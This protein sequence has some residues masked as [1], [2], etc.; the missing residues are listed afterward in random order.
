MTIPVSHD[1]RRAVGRRR[2]RTH[3]LQPKP[4]PHFAATPSRWWRCTS[5]PGRCTGPGRWWSGTRRRRFL[6]PEAPAK[7]AQGGP[8]LRT[9]EHRP[10]SSTASEWPARR[11][12][13]WQ[14]KARHDWRCSARVGACYAM[15]EW[16]PRPGQLQTPLCCGSTS[17][18]CERWQSSR[19]P[20]FE[21][22][23]YPA[24]S[25]RALFV[26]HLWTSTEDD[27]DD[28]DWSAEGER[29]PVRA[30]GWGQPSAARAGSAADAALP[31]AASTLSWCSSRRPGQ[32]LV[33]LAGRRA[34][35][36]V[37]HALHR[38]GCRTLGVAQLRTSA[39]RATTWTGRQRVRGSAQRCSLGRRRV[40]VVVCASALATPRLQQRPLRRD[41]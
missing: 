3:Q 15:H 11:Q 38:P 25:R 20:D 12:Q 4:T 7:P 10:D 35:A 41:P 23:H 14:G 1:V 19:E 40:V 33:P 31:T 32:Q 17:Q 13:R 9:G 29:G 16:L 39:T 26:A 28:D 6:P 37:Q 21:A 34:R 36:V 8:C 30:G 22:S 2:R 5:P 27:S 24:Q 18:P